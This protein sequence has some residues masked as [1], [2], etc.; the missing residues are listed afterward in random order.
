MPVNHSNYDHRGR[1]NYGI[2]IRCPNLVGDR[3][4]YFD[5]NNDSEHWVIR[6]FIAGQKLDNAHSLLS[7]ADIEADAVGDE[8][9]PWLD[10]KRDA[11]EW[12]FYLR[13]RT[14]AVLRLRLSGPSTVLPNRPSDT[15]LPLP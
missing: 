15:W 6:D 2:V 8:F 11:V 7:V 13:T 12:Q 14:N 10:V 1:G 9:P 5:Y 3:L 4:V